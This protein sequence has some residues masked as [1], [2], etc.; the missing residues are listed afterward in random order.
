MMRAC[1]SFL[2]IA[3]L[4]VLSCGP[5][6]SNNSKNAI[7][8]PSREAH[9]EW[10]PIGEGSIH[11]AIDCTACHGDNDSFTTIACTDC[12]THAQ[13]VEDQT[14]ADVGGYVYASESCYACHPTAEVP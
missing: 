6:T 12:H 5:N 7:T 11:V 3:A 14:H 13:S 4:V 10:F 1:W 9:I 2:R 8:A